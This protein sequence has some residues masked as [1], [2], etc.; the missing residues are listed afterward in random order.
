VAQ[1]VVTTALLALLPASLAHAAGGFR[2]VSAGASYTC[3]VKV[4]DT[5]AC[6]G[7]NIYGQAT[8]PAGNF[9]SVSA[10][11]ERA[12]AVRA[13]DTLACWGL[14]GYGRRLLLPGRS[15]R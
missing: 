11:P 5:L 13:N 10:G 8:P 1:L 7:R 9:K 6:W 12:C 3:A 15:C 14:D 4:D 2:S